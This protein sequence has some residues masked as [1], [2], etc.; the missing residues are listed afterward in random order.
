MLRWTGWRW[1]VV[2]WVILGAGG[3][4]THQFG[5]VPGL[6]FLAVC[7]IAAYVAERASR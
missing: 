3:W 2:A 5:G 7:A 1:Q 4:V 6:V